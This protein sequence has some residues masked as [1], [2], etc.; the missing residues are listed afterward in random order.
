MIVQKHMLWYSLEA[1]LQ[2]ASNKYPQHIFLWR[3]K[4]NIFML[5]PPIWSYAV[6]YM[7]IGTEHDV[8]DNI[9]SL[10]ETTQLDVYCVTFDIIT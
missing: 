5:A 10:V 8:W 7:Y 9:D 4:K 3:N 6:M 1:P 2:G